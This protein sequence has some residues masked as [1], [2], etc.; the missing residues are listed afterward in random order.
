[1]AVGG[2]SGSS[3]SHGSERGQGCHRHEPRKASPHC[4]SEG[5]EETRADTLPTNEVVHELMGQSFW[6]ALEYYRQQTGNHGKPFEHLSGRRRFPGPG[7]NY[8]PCLHLHKLRRSLHL[9]CLCEKGGKEGLG[10]T[11]SA[12]VTVCQ[13]LGGQTASAGGEP[14]ALW[15]LCHRTG[16]TTQPSYFTSNATSAHNSARAV[17]S[18]LD[19]LA[20]SLQWPPACSAARSLGTSPASVSGGERLACP[21]AQCRRL[22]LQLDLAAQSPQLSRCIDQLVRVVH[23]YTWTRPHQCQILNKSAQQQPYSVPVPLTG[24]LFWETLYGRWSK[25]SSPRPNDLR[26]RST[27]ALCERCRQPTSTSSKRP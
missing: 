15:Q 3:L 1:M 2:T 23:L 26:W 10:G 9:L 16:S 7:P 22:L 24:G 6:V 19:Q 21:R 8:Q 12:C 13:T 17:G 4:I 20:G 5:L 27:V 14:H 11:R 18:L 25:A